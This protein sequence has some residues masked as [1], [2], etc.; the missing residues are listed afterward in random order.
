MNV[1]IAI[2]EIWKL[3]PKGSDNARIL[4]KEGYERFY[5]R[6]CKLLNPDLSF[7]K[8]QQIVKVTLLPLPLS[9]LLIITVTAR[10]A[11]DSPIPLPLPLLS[12]LP[13][14]TVRLSTVP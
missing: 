1:K 7:D 11:I 14:V 2:N 13:N 8:A 6:V 12:P 3:I 9:L 5:M 10:V 4:T